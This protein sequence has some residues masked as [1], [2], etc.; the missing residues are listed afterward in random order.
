MMMMSDSHSKVVD[1]VERASDGS[2]SAVAPPYSDFSHQ[3]RQEQQDT[4]RSRQLALF[5]R[6]Y[7]ARMTTGS[8]LITPVV[9]FKL[10]VE[11]AT[12]SGSAA[13]AIL[14]RRVSLNGRF[15][16]LVVEQGM[17]AF[18]AYLAC[19][20]MALAAVSSTSDV[21]VVTPVSR[22][23]P[24]WERSYGCFLNTVPI[25]ATI[26]ALASVD[27]TLRSCNT[28]LLDAMEHASVP[29][30]AIVEAAGLKASNFPIMFVFHS[31]QGDKGQSPRKV[32][33]DVTHQIRTLAGSAKPKFPLTFSVTV[34]PEAEVVGH[35]LVDICVDFNQEAMPLDS[36]RSLCDRYSNILEYLSSDEPEKIAASIAQLNILTAHDRG[37][38]RETQAE[39][40]DIIPQST[41]R[42]HDL[43][44]KRVQESP[45]SVACFF[46]DG[47]AKTTYQ[48]LW[49]SVTC[50][51]ESL[52]PLH[53]G[54]GDDKLALFMA[55]GVERVAAI[56]G[57]LCAG[58]AYVPLDVSWPALRIKAIIQ[59][60]K[61]VAIIT[62]D[63]PNTVEHLAVLNSSLAALSERLPIVFLS[64]PLVNDGASNKAA[65]VAVASSDLA[66]VLYTSGSTGTPK[67]VQVEH[68]ALSSSIENHV[69][70]YQLNRH[71]SRLLQL[72]PWT[73]DVSVVDILATL[74]IGA[75]LCIG[76]KDYLLSR[77]P[78]IIN[79]ASVTHLATTPTLAALIDP[80]TCP[81]L[82]VLAVGGEPMTE[83]VRD[84]WAKAV[85]LLNVYGPTE[86]T[87]NVTAT[88]VDFDSNV[89]VIGRSLSNMKTYVLNERLQQVPC[90]TVGQL[91][92][93][94]PQLARGYTDEALNENAFVV[95]PVFGRLFLTGT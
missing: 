86:A 13:A 85:R 42:V 69:R 8:S 22:R 52:A 59:D 62:T 37:K 73:F 76:S 64:R 18:S 4:T 1:R 82:E 74:S 56:I 27:E 20:Q 57:A 29:Y 53:R 41:G 3:E 48:D 24:R 75:T 78:Q 93:A 49:T 83:L 87:V 47:G 44:R 25:R 38:L 14:S 80:S 63:D 19:F 94:G 23:M 54:R 77:L 39:Q 60:V 7:L 28:V 71:T 92:V 95:H 32:L 35:T 10:P 11:Q 68:G 26:E 34:K 45:N 66:Y 2:Q 67:G 55:P 33:V 12:A 6:Y 72:A 36:V 15:S 90:G 89:A 79:A 31:H 88:T 21:V 40:V 43:I 46:E 9:S 81:T 16:E 70:L 65:A 84:V 61:P 91:A 30:E 50:I 58:F 5:W 17:T 51:S